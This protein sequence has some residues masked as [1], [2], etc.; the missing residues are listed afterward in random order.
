MDSGAARQHTA[1]CL[2]NDGYPVS[3]RPRQAYPVIPDEQAEAL[4][5]IRVIDES[6]EDYLYPRTR[7]FHPVPPPGKGA[8]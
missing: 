1:T 4:G 2:N 5:F 8:T 7:F 6:G 3:L